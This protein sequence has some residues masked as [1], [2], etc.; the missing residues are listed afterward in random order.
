MD[1]GLLNVRR[2]IQIAATPARVWQEFESF[3]RMA[4]WWG[5]GHTLAVYEPH[6]GGRIEMT[7]DVDGEPRRYGGPI[8]VFDAARELTIES[9]W[10]PPR[11]WPVPTYLTI[12]LAP[13]LSGTLVELFHHGFERMGEIAADQHMGY[14]E[15][16]SMRQL[17]MLRERAEA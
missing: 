16:W 9:S 2:S 17:V 1:I 15:G 14:E 4:A 5:T 12:R 6:V 3:D 8:T 11:D 10:I 13:A 7:V